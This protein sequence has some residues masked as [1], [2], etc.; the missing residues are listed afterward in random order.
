MDSDEDESGD[1]FLY[2]L[3]DG[4]EHEM[5][6]GTENDEDQEEANDDGLPQSDDEEQDEEE[7][8][9]GKNLLDAFVAFYR[10]SLNVMALRT[11]LCPQV[12]RQDSRLTALSYRPTTKPQ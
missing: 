4:S 10:T 2:A 8:D 6:V 12:C 9:E 5:D 11:L 3:N 7:G 1:S